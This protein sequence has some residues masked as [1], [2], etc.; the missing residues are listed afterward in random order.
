[1]S[2][3]AELVLVSVVKKE[4]EEK[5]TVAPGDIYTDGRNLDPGSSSFFSDYLILLVVVRAL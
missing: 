4:R 1:V 3:N 2:E 5:K